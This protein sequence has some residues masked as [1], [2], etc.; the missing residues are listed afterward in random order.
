MT[1]PW[2]ICIVYESR[3]LSRCHPEPSMRVPHFSRPLREVG[4]LLAPSLFTTIDR[5]LLSWK[6]SDVAATRR[7]NCHVGNTR[8]LVLLLP[9][10]SA[11]ATGDPK[12]HRHHLQREI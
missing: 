5:F 9:V 11:Q 6:C 2:D 3:H 10:S 12:R 7:K 8:S 1:G 4:F